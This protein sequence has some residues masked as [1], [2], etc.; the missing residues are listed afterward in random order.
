MFVHKSLAVVTLGGYAPLT[1][2]GPGSVDWLESTYQEQYR[3]EA[4][5]ILAI[6][7]DRPGHEFD[8]LV[9]AGAIDKLLALAAV[10]G[11]THRATHRE[12]SPRYFGDG[13][14]QVSI[15]RHPDGWIV[16]PA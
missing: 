5:G 7:L 14:V 4:R 12:A 2:G 16:L 15:C 3:D 1:E 11:Y 10:H 13:S 8:C 6:D 9:D